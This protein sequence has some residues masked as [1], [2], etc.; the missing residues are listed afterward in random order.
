M[1]KGEDCKLARKN[2]KNTVQKGLTVGIPTLGRAVSL[3]WAFAYKSL[4]PPINYNTVT[5]VVYNK[6]VDIARNE[7]VAL[8][9]QNDHKYI[10]FMGDDTVPPHNILK[11][12]IFRAENNKDHGIIT[13]VYC[14]KS[15]PPAPLLFRGNG[16]GSYWDWKVG[17]YFQ[18][19]GCGMDAVLIA[20]DVFHELAPHVGKDRQGNLEFFK[21]VETDQFEDGVNAAQMWTEDLYFLDLVEKHSSYKIYC[22]GGMLCDHVDVNTGRVYQLRPDSLPIR[23]VDSIRGKAGNKKAIDIGCGRTWWNPGSDYDLIRVDIREECE[24]DYRCDIRSLPFDKHSFDLVHSSHVL[25][26]FPRAE[27]QDVLKEWIRVLKPDGE[28]RLVLPNIRWAAEQLTS[29]VELTAEMKNHVMNVLYGAQTN[30]YDFH[31][32]GWTPDSI[33]EALKELQFKKFEWQHVGYNMIVQAWR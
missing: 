9:M 5:A 6:P 3:N 26:H 18:I 25:E 21:T 17:E 14:S 13:G 15:D 33:E 7:I 11:Q 32:N 31:Y 22:D 2:M 1:E 20:V 16:V 23:G 24:P 10:Y 27:W 12:L 28:M 4:V 30:P 29:G 8:A 19:S